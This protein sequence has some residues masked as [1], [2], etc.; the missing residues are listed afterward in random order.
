[1]RVTQGLGGWMDGWGMDEWGIDG[2]MRTGGSIVGCAGPLDVFA[3]R[4]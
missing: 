1:M 3:D 2:W 4:D